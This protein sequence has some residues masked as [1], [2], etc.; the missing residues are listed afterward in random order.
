LNKKSSSTG[1]L[2]SIQN[3]VLAAIAWAV[4]ALLFFLI[5]SV[6]EPGQ[7][8]PAWYSVATYILE[9]V[10]FLGAGLLCLRNWKSSQIVSGVGVWLAFG[11]GMLSYF[12]GNLILAYWE[13][14]WGKSPEISPGDFFF[15]LTYLFLGW[16]M[17]QAV[18]SKKL[19]LSFVQWVVLALITAV[20]IMVASLFTPA[21][22]TAAVADVVPTMTIAQVPAPRTGASPKPASA[23][24]T[25]ATSTATP[26]ASPRSTP[27]AVPTT[28]APSPTPAVVAMPT[29][30]PASPGASQDSPA[31]AEEESRAPA[32]AIELEKTLSPLSNTISWMYV[33]GDVILI[34]MATM[35][36]LA[37]WGGKFSLSWRF[38]A[39][40]SISFYISDIWFNYANKNIPDYQT[41]AL[42][43]VFW[44]FSG[45]LFAIGAILEYDLSTRRRSSRRRA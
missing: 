25:K 26:K 5:F 43:E 36:L 33:V 1:S 28:K 32:W 18:I 21:P 29:T 15:I 42:L 30:A 44:I 23:P 34:V 31:E 40:G 14:G 27:V 7:E 9:E 41:G 4:I 12:T 13:I 20:G 11:L 6:A 17:L 19:H 45:C 8:R 3:V 37:Y 35:L 2:L 10:S 24:S 38:I 39:A 16:G 22:A